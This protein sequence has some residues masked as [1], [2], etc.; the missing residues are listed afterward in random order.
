MEFN[1]VYCDVSLPVPL[2][3]V[4]TYLLPETLRHP[5]SGLGRGCWRHLERENWRGWCSARTT[6]DPLRRRANYCGCSMKSPALDEELLKLGSWI[7]SYYCAPLGEVLRAMTPLGGDLRRGKIFSLT[8]SGRD[9]ARQLHLNETN[10]QDPAT[11]ILRLL[12]VRALSASYLTKKVEKAA[13]VLRSLEKKGFVEVEDVAA[14]RDPLRASAARLRAEF[15]R[16]PAAEKLAKAE[17]ELLSYLELHPGS[18]NVAELEK[19]VSKASI[20][21]RALARLDLVKLTL[22]AIAGSAFPFRAPHELNPHQKAAYFRIEKAL[23]AKQFQTFLLQGVT[24]SGKTEIY[25]KAIDAALAMGKGALMLVPEIGLTCRAVAGHGFHHR[26]G[27]RVAILHSG[28]H[29]S[30]RTQG[31]G[32]ASDQAKPGWWSPHDRAFLR[33]S[34][35]LASSSSTRN[36]IRVTSSRRRHAITGATWRL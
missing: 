8:K 10:T 3:Q 28:I 35:T 30:E 24:G 9:A 15:V 1:P 26:F 5:G 34:R 14:E 29:D 23:E 13:V 20:A 25:L 33:R 19:S 11:E 22:E 31:V 27:G 7:A 32:G 17:R 36:T 4:F 2:D 21:A 12:D 18:H 16:R 6:S